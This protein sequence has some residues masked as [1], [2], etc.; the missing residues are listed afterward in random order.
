LPNGAVGLEHALTAPK[1]FG[2]GQE[3]R[4]V[5]KDG[6][7]PA[8]GIF[9]V[10]GVQQFEGIAVIEPDAARSV[11]ISQARRCWLGDGRWEMGVGVVLPYLR[12][13]ISY[14]F[15]GGDAAIFAQ[16][17][18][19]GRNGM[20][21]RDLRIA[22]EVRFPMRPAR[23]ARPTWFRRWTTIKGLGIVNCGLRIAE[24][25]PEGLAFPLLASGFWL[26]ASAFGAFFG[27]P[28][29]IDQKGGS[30]QVFLSKG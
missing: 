5:G 2:V 23:R 7:E 3:I 1:A 21:G 25:C 6:V 11:G 15:A 18:M 14:L 17:K 10:D 29:S 20:V 12:T 28:R 4:R 24:S 9:G 30:D 26:L 8:I 16:F 22:I 13:A 27:T 19:R